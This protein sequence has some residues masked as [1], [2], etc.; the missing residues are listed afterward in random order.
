MLDLLHAKGYA[1]VSLFHNGINLLLN[2]HI[3]SSSF[4]ASTFG[5]G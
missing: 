4:M 2:P 5:F 1:S 3:F